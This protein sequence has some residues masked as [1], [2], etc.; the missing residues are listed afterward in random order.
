MNALQSIAAGIFAAM[1]VASSA[2]AADPIGTSD[3]DGPPIE[4][5]KLKKDPEARFKI[6]WDHIWDHLKN[7]KVGEDGKNTPTDIIAHLDDYRKMFW[8]T[9]PKEKFHE[10]AREAFAQALFLKDIHY[11]QSDLWIKSILAGTPSANADLH[12][13]T[14]ENTL[15]QV[16]RKSVV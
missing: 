3:L 14:P 2:F 12:Q 9:Y 5:D 6:M 10:E 15:G 13:D 1:L 8:A 7:D 16:D 11:L 4:G